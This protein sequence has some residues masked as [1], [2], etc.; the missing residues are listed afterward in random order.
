MTEVDK[1]IIIR[2]LEQVVDPCS[3]ATGV[4]IG[5]ASMGLIEDVRCE[6][7]QVHIV[8]RL[9]SPICWQAA[10]ILRQSEAKIGQLEGVV[11]V[12]CEIDAAAE[13]SM[14]LINPVY[15]GRLRALRP[16][17]KRGAI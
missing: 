9:T 11:S 1:D 12:N 7:G 3:I 14:E 5:L 10:N 15:L 16:H 8:L 4:P 17:A 13:W 2:A 6:G